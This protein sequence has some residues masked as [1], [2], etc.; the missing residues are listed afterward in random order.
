MKNRPMCL[1][2]IIL[3]LTVSLADR[4]GLS[5]IWRGSGSMV[6]EQMARDGTPATAQGIVEKRE[7]KTYTTYLIIKNATLTV[8]SVQY[9]IR[10]IK[11]EAKAGEIY[12]PGQSVCLQGM[13]ALPEEPGNPGE[14]H[15]LRYERARKIDYYLENTRLVG[16]GSSFSPFRKILEQTREACIGQMTRIF[17]PREA[18]I[19]SAMLLGDKSGVE[20]EIKDWYQYA[21]ISHIMAI[22][23]LHVTLLGMTVWKI[24]GF[25]RIP[26]LLSALASILLL[27][28]YGI[29]IGG[30][31]SAVRAILMF[32][33][34]MGARISGRSYDLLS[35]L[36]LAAVFLVLDN[37]DVIYDS[38][39]WLS[40]TAVLGV[41]AVNP[42]FQK[43]TGKEMAA[44]SWNMLKPGVILWLT[45][46]PV[47]LAAFS[48][49]SLAGLFWNLLVIPLVPVVLVSGI[50]ALGVGF[51]HV[52]A[53]SVAGIP[54]WVMLQM[55]AFAGW[56]TEKLPAGMWTPGQPQWWRILLYYLLGTVLLA[57]AVYQKRQEKI[58]KKEGSSRRKPVP[59]RRRRILQGAV[60]AGMLLTM[61]CRPRWGMQITMLD[62]GQG[63][64][65]LAGAD[66]IWSLVDGGSSSRSQVGTYV[67]WPY[68]KSQGITRL[69]AV[70]VTHPDEDHKNGIEELL[71]LAD[72]GGLRIDRLFL[73]EWMR[74]EEDGFRLCELARRAGTS[75]IFLKQGDQIRQGKILMTVL[76]PRESGHWEDGNGGSLVISWKY[77]EIHG[78]FMGDLPSEEEADI[79]E[80]VDP[81]D[82]LKVGH[83]GS[84][85]S[86]SERF[87]NR[88]SP[89]AA[90]I[91]CGLHNRYG[92]PGK[93]TME[94]LRAQNC[95]IFRTDTMGAV[96]LTAQK[97]KLEIS[98]FRNPDGEEAEGGT[99]FYSCA[100]DDQKV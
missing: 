15:R 99:A 86:S 63:D 37:P 87:L 59:E 90:L 68:L 48:Q 89:E 88:A 18:G 24:L 96:T 49:V 80:W 61:G 40:F 33:V 2:A 42:V 77:Q 29:W 8:Q 74:Q 16:K 11:C 60:V 3:V 41:G 58:R 17:P 67:I 84:S 26:M 36:S 30:S 73:P 38:G 56:V 72:G 64:A 91:S 78:L 22:S 19:L 35:A 34:W 76:H 79:L 54:A 43:K 32:A 57:E 46:L 52:G 44:R 94:R 66:G 31:A 65:I 82:F 14:F 27:T 50:A 70:F 85:G 83:H 93:D 23:G 98:S 13:L 21:G 62:V 25:F 92:H 39:F 55:Y 69:D 75:C 20:Q 12:Q 6:L 10:K 95:M 7:E 1:L 4:R 53:G 51:F 9:P 71:L 28:L 47:V 81:C 100:G 45:T 97:G 5:W